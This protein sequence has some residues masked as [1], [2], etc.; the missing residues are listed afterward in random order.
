[1]LAGIEARIGSCEYGVTRAQE[2]FA[3]DVKY[4]PTYYISRPHFNQYF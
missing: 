3:R 2:K 1:V 4:A